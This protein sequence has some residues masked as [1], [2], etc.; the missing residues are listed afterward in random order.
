MKNNEEAVDEYKVF[1]ALSSG[2][3]WGLAVSGKLASGK[4]TI[5]ALVMQRLNADPCSQLSWA[6]PLKDEMDAILA[7]IVSSF[8]QGTAIDKV[9]DRGISHSEASHLVSELWH[10]AASL[11]ARART[12]KVRW[13]LQF[14]GTNVRRAQ[15]PD[16]WVHRAVATAISTV[17]AGT[18]VYFTDC[19]FPNEV[20]AARRIGLYT[21]RLEVSATVQAERLRNRDGLRLDHDAASHPSETAL[22]GYSGFDLVVNND[23][24]IYQAVEVIVAGMQVRA[25]KI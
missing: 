4:D 8:D 11:H 16:Y 22:D 9:R 6:T 25:R 24:P 23:G 3:V 18:S 5:A 15:D 17:G 19:R 7:D 13:A 20:E 14:L 1:A 21:V 12:P 10:D 2:D